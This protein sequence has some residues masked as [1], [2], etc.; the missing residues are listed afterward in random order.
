[1]A[2]MDPNDRY[3]Q[4]LDVAVDVAMSDGFLNL[5]H[6]KVASRA[7][8]VK[9]TVFHHFK[10]IDILRDAVMTVAI[11]DSI[12]PIIA[13]GITMGNTVAIQAPENVKRDALLSNL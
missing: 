8:V 12:K 9:G 2:R 3:K 5:T 6:S 10:S 13:T 11:D 1:M 4:L 7:N